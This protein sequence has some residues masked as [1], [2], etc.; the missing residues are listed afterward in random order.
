M[1]GKTFYLT[2]MV[3][4]VVFWNLPDSEAI[5]VGQHSY[6]NNSAPCQ[7]CHSDVQNMLDQYQPAY[8]YHNALTCNGCHAPDGNSSHAA[9]ISTCIECHDSEHQTPYPV[10]NECH[11]SHGAQ[12][13]GIS[14]GNGYSCE[15][16][17]STQSPVQHTTT[18]CANCHSENDAVDLSTLHNNDC[19]LCH[20]NPAITLPTSANCGNCHGFGSQTPDS[21]HHDITLHEFYSSECVSCHTTI[22]NTSVPKS[23]CSKC[24]DENDLYSVQSLSCDMCHTQHGGSE[25]FFVESANA[26]S[27]EGVNCDLCHNNVDIVTLPTNKNCTSCHG[28]Q[29]PTPHIN[30]S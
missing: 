6:Y 21:G 20:D 5:M 29:L 26:P 3:I 1:N 30:G 2:L 11:D 14:H 24:H 9:R 10:C 19:G 22:H 7:K 17:H 23:G 25:N 15:S 27:V 13:P 4:G 12:Y 16:C 18:V 28:E 8:I